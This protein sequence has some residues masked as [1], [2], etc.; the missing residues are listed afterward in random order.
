[1]VSLPRALSSWGEMYDLMGVVTR[2][3]SGR[4]QSTWAVCYTRSHKK[5]NDPFQAAYTIMALA[6]AEKVRD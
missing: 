6:Y 1:V 2:T 5:M 4:T 3:A